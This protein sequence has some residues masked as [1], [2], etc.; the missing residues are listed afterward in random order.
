[1]QIYKKTND[2]KE[3]IERLQMLADRAE[4]HEYQ[5]ESD[6]V[7]KLSD[8]KAVLEFYET[9]KVESEPIPNVPDITPEW[10]KIPERY[11]FVSIDSDGAECAYS[12]KPYNS[13]SEWRVN[14][15]W[16]K[17]GRKFDMSVIDWTKTL[18]K[19]PVK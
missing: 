5:N 13:C 16:N 12:E 9:H 15:H 4:K 17:T 2:M 8:I 6:V 19:R 11:T 18:S 7:V 10:D 3:T 1:M 14:G